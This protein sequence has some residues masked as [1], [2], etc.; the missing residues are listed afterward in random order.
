MF[1]DP[2]REAAGAAA[3]SY[4]YSQRRIGHE[5]AAADAQM[6]GR[7]PIQQGEGGWV[8]I[9]ERRATPAPG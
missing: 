5:V 8:L 7:F 6:A 1:A 2:Q 9:I 3:R 4:A